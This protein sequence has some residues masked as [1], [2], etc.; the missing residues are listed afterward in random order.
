VGIV[1]AIALG[2]VQGLTEFIPV[3][4]SGHLVLGQELF[5]VDGGGLRFDVALHIG[6]LAAL[7]VYFGRD[8]VRLVRGFPH[9]GND[10][11][12]AKLLMYAT[13]PAAVAGYFLQDIAETSFRNPLLVAGTLAAVGCVMLFAEWRAERHPPATKLESVTLRQ[14]LSIGGAQAVALIPGVSRSGATITAGLLLGLDRVSATRFSFLLAIPITI[15]AVLKVVVFDGESIV[16]GGDAS[17]LVAG[18]M[19]AFASGLLAIRFLLRYLS[20]H[21]LRVFAWYRIGLALF[22][23]LVV[24][25][26]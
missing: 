20:Q 26:R 16:S 19:A 2:I 13:V 9:G 25:L 17:V 15:G 23:V 24:A 1:E 4:S 5:G 14:A 22:A 6:T 10:A 21:S 8:L 18:I 11:R 7:I 12:I 3:S